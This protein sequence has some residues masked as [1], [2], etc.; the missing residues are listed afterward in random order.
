MREGE[1]GRESDRVG[2]GCRERE[3]EIEREIERVSE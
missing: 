2:E 3:I 1:G